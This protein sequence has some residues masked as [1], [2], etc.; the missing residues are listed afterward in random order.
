MNRLSSLFIHS[1]QLF[2][3]EKVFYHSCDGFLSIFLF[4]KFSV[5]IVKFY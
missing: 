2:F 3:Y 5:S 4:K 1:C